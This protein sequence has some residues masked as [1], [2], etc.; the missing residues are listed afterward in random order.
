MDNFGES[1]AHAPRQTGGHRADVDVYPEFDENLRERVPGGDPAVRLDRNCARYRASRESCSPPTNLR[2]RAART[3]LPDRGNGHGSGEQARQVHGR[4]AGWNRRTGRPHLTATRY[5]T[6]C[7]PGPRPVAARHASARR[8]LRRRP[9]CL[10]CRRTTPMPV[11]YLIGEKMEVH[12]RI[13]RAP[14]ARLRTD[15][16][17]FA[18]ENFD[19]LGKWRTMADSAPIDASASLPDGYGARRRGQP[20]DLV[21]EHPRGFRA[22]VHE[23]LLGFA[24]G[25]GTESADLS[26]VRT[27]RE[28][29]QPAV[30]RWS[31]LSG[32][33]REHAVQHEHGTEGADTGAG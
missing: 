11:P 12:R 19:A 13:P 25:R 10:R 1:V 14:R 21:A 33:R 18:L 2:E 17:G 26:A 22:H 20:R 29:R 3:A 16:L 32:H 30:Y 8:R 6:G 27:S 24:L 15:P 5:P 28:R 23:E 31:S 9:T 4:Q 7:R